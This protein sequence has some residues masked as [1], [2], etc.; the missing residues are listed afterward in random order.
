MIFSPARLGRYEL[1]RF[2]GP[3]PKLALIFVLLVPLLYSAIYLSA[4]WDP[5]GR[6]DRL[7]VA[8]VDLDRPTTV[9]GPDDEQRTVHAGPDL[10]EINGVG[11]AEQIQRALV[12]RAVEPVQDGHRHALCSAARQ[13]RDH[14]A[15]LH[16]RI[17]CVTTCIMSAACCSSVC[18]RAIA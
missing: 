14:E 8:V 12:T 15:D 1:R 6:L 13:R 11:G 3:L 17:S 18:A 16:A 2:R 9:D 10:V 4:N 7:P 5:Y